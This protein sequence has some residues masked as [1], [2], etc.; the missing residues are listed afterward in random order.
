MGHL[1]ND[2]GEIKPE[3]ALSS[4]AEA[5]SKEPVA[6]PAVEIEAA[7]P[8]ACCGC[9]CSSGAAEYSGET[10]GHVGFNPRTPCTRVTTV[11]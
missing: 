9:G 10:T 2:S 1:A 4:A 8:K 3:S 11:A 6:T 5:P 7:G